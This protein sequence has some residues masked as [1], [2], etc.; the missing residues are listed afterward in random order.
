VRVRLSIDDTGLD[1][2]R[3]RAR[4]RRG[5]HLPVTAH[6]G[7]GWR[8]RDAR[9]RQFYTTARDQDGRHR[10]AVRNADTRIEREAEQL[11]DRHDDLRSLHRALRVAIRRIE[12]SPVPP[13]LG[14]IVMNIH[15][16]HFDRTRDQRGGPALRYPYTIGPNRTSGAITAKVRENLLR[17]LRQDVERAITRESRSGK[18]LRFSRLERIL[19]REVG[20]SSRRRRVLRRP[21]VEKAGGNLRATVRVSGQE[22]T[23]AR[24]AR[25]PLPTG[26]SSADAIPITWYKPMRAYQS[27]R[28]LQPIA[29]RWSS[30]RQG[31]HA[32]AN[33]RARGSMSFR[34]SHRL[35][36]PPSLY[37]NLLLRRFWRRDGER[38]YITL[39][40]RNAYLP[41]RGKNLRRGRQRE[42]TTLTSAY[43]SLLSG[44]RFSWSGLNADHV[45]DIGWGGPDNIANLWPLSATANSSGNRIYDE[46]VEYEAPD[47]RDTRQRPYFL[48]GKFFRI[49]AIRTP[50]PGS[51]WPP[52][53]F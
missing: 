49:H 23:V 41:S 21:R 13:L 43:R 27:I 30:R 8:A 1:G 16:E 47:G 25:Y 39:G 38:R 31:P 52:T 48:S 42:R 5:R 17:K 24:V 35:E 9:R 10:R 37:G 14:G 51:Y 19:T 7:H 44:Y 6:H 33:P 2:W 12:R 26:R 36:V 22:R 20:Q 29:T 3:V 40:V 18:G 4:A 45:E 46:P 34:G 32:P 28:G 50:P 53:P 11:A 15:E